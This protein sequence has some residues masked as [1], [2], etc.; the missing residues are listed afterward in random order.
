MTCRE[1]TDF[2]M[3]YFSGQLPASVHTEFER[4]LVD[5]PECSTYLKS[6]EETVR[7]G[8]AAFTELDTAVPVEVP[9]TLVQAILA[10][11]RREQ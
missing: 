8:K 2:L 9:E 5:C 6:Y 3:E 10:S 4:H 1:F 7:L 11:R